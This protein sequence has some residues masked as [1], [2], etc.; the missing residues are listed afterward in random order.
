MSLSSTG[1]DDALD[2]K[3]IH[4]TA[5]TNTLNKNV[6]LAPGKLFSCKAVNSSSSAA[7]VKIFDDPSPTIGTTDPVLVFP[8]AGNATIIYAIPDGLDFTTLSFAATL[9]QN[10]L[11]QTAPSGATVAITLVCS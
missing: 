11:D 1:F 4:E 3:L 5:A 6:T 9:N 2:H 10:P 7:Y 8:V